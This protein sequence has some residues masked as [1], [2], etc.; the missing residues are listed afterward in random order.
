MKIR[1][2]LTIAALLMTMTACGTQ[3]GSKSVVVYYSQNGTTA[4]VA[5]HIAT[6]TGADVI[7]LQCE[8]PYPSDFQ[9]TIA[10]SQ[11]ECMNSTG[12][13]LVQ[14]K[15]D[16]S[17]YDTIYIGYPIWFGTYAP[18]I[19]TLANDNDFAGKNVVLFCTYGSGGRLASENNF[20][21]MCPDA[22]VLGSYGISARKVELAADEIPAFLNELKNPSE[23]MVGAYSEAR[24]L[25]AADSAVF[26]VAMADYGYLNLSP[27]SVS[28]Q[29]AAGMNYIFNCEGAGP[30]GQASKC[31]ALIFKPL[32]G[33]PYLKSVER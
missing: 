11:S 12:R 16:F 14:S 33:D 10:E 15:F 5:Q 3:T 25:T 24:E 7:E 27:V 17:A 22:N 30:D 18:P 9:A 19:V 23:K 20:K 29:V 6:A 13:A 32:D 1:F 2:L 21:A 4:Q 28:T 26:N 31:Q 8:V